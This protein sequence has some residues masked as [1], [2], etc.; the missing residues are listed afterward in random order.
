MSKWA[1][2]I[3][4]VVMMLVGGVGLSTNHWFFWSMLVLGMV[5]VLGVIVA[6]VME[7]NGT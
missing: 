2:L 3:A 5:T 7:V 6:R 4:G 1:Y